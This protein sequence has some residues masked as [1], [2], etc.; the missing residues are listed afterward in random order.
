M[1]AAD[2]HR[3]IVPVV[4]TMA[5]L[6]TDDDVMTFDARACKH[7]QEVLSEAVQSQHRDGSHHHQ[8]WHAQ[9]L[10]TCV[11]KLASNST[12]LKHL[13]EQ[14]APLLESLMGMLGFDESH[15]ETAL[16]TMW[17]LASTD[18]LEAFA[19]LPKFDETLTSLTKSDTESVRQAAVRLKTK[20]GELGE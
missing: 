3:V 1:D 18:S 5:N 12:N 14:H 2:D 6:S 8:G 7:L 17:S 11:G 13:L 20:I 4:V 15:Q 16:N 9:E 19:I 10:A